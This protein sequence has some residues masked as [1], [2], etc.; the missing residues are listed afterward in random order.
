MQ[1]IVNVA[2]FRGTSVM[3]P[4]GRYKPNCKWQGNVKFPLKRNV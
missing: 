3:T 1:I 4:L 2:F